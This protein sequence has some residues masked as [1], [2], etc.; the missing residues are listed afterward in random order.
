MSILVKLDAVVISSCTLIFPYICVD[1]HSIYLYD[2]ISVCN[3]N[4]T[5]LKS[6]NV[7]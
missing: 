2:N 1:K 7:N 4:H 5:Q 3:F 6:V